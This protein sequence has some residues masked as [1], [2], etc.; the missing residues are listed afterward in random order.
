M[1][2]QGVAAPPAAE[3]A[4]QLIPVAPNQLQPGGGQDDFNVTDVVDRK[5]G[6]S[7]KLQTGMNW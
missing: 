2:A 4:R 5:S 1:H 6:G 7:G 3:V